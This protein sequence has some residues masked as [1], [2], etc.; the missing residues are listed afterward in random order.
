[1][2]LSHGLSL[3]VLC[4]LYSRKDM[5]SY[6]AFVLCSIFSHL[7][8]C[9]F[10]FFLNDFCPLIIITKCYSIFK[11]KLLLFFKSELVLPLKELQ[12]ETE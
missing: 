9:I 12:R 1:M 10:F 7:S 5:N 4:A 8:L 3:L 6:E 2:S 11:K